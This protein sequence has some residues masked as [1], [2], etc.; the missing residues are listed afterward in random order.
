LIDTFFTST[1]KPTLGNVG[2]VL[3]SNLTVMLVSF[4][5]SIFY[6]AGAIF[7]ITLNASVF[8][9]FVVFVAQY[10]AETIKEI[11]MIIGLFM[12]HMVPEIS[13]FL[14][15]AIAGGVLSKALMA[16]KWSSQ[17]FRNVIKDSLM[18][19]VIASVLIVVAAFLEVYVTTFMFHRFV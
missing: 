1:L 2:S 5:L 19:L 15:A 17:R 16:E 11:F 6:G 14:I 3:E 13:G 10:L 9:S 7:L 4:V 8:A 12:I 18:L